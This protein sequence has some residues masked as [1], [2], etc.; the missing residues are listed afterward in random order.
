MA[1]KMMQESIQQFFQMASQDQELQSKLKAAPNREAYISLVVELGK[2]KGYSF[3]SAQVGSALDTAA[4][5]AVENGEEAS[6][7]LEEE[8]DAVAGGTNNPPPPNP[9]TPPPTPPA[10]TG[11]NTMAICCIVNVVDDIFD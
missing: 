1:E 8:L 2:E 7:L 9:P 5:E 4:K 11:G 3:T 6:Q 10:G